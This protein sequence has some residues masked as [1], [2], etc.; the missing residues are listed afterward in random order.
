MIAESTYSVADIAHR[1]GCQDKH[2]LRL[3]A[4]GELHAV[5]VALRPDGKRPRW[6]I[7]SAALDDFEQRR[8]NGPQEKQPK[9]PRRKRLASEVI[10]FF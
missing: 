5:N 4:S 9:M 3:I 8:A 1:W 10:E 7:G 6:R 2:V